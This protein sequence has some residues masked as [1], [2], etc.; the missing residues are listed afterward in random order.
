MLE[1][2]LRIFCSFLIKSWKAMLSLR[3]SGVT[4]D[5]ELSKK[6][7]TEYSLRLTVYPGNDEVVFD[8]ISIP[9]TSIANA[10]WTFYNNPPNSPVMFI[11]T[12]IKRDGEYLGDK[13]PTKII[14]QPKVRSE[15]PVE[16][17]FVIKVLKP[18][19][20]IKISL[21]GGWLNKLTI[22]RALP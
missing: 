12:V 14:V 15:K 18:M 5:A 21:T 11:G 4:F 19:N 20:K 17:I 22:K 13:I 10:A 2:G 6:S 3:A 1:D 16:E 9:N 8:E 7:D